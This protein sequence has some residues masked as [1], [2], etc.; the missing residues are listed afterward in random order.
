MKTFVFQFS[1][2]KRNKP[3]VINQFT[4][5]YYPCVEK[6]KLPAIINNV[7]MCNPKFPFFVGI[8]GGRMEKN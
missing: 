8:G 5:A 3:C 6:E 1:E 2:F 4:E 7:G